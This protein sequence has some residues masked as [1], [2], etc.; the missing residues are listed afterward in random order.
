MLRG[1]TK[2]A[3]AFTSVRGILEPLPS[4]PL[5]RRLR[6]ARQPVERRAIHALVGCAIK[7]GENV[8]T[9]TH[10]IYFWP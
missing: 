3:K 7:S 8:E 1:V 6:Y 5:P 10:S 2:P 4:S 9:S